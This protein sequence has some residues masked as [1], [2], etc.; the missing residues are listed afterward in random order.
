MIELNKL[1]PPALKAAM[2]GGTAAWGQMGSASTHV[3]YVELITPKSRKKCHCGC[4]GKKTH[5]GMANGVCLTSSCHLS[6]LRWAKG[7]K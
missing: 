7:G 4:G 5:K 2:Q 1:S 6:A 3:R